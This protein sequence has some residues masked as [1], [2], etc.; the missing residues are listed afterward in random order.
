MTVSFPTRFPDAG[1]LPRTGQVRPHFGVA[2]ELVRIAGDV[3]QRRAEAADEL[4]A[5]VGADR[6]RG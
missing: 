1:R 3:V 4:L 6:S 2:A 5:G